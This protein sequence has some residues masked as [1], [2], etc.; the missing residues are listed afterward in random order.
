[1]DKAAPDCEDPALVAGHRY[2]GPHRSRHGVLP[3][4]VEAPIHGD[5][6]A[7]DPPGEDVHC[8]QLFPSGVPSQS[9]PQ[10]RLVERAS[11]RLAS[12]RAPARNP[13]DWITQVSL[14]AQ[15]A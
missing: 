5:L 7:I 1:M 2:D 12:H 15:S 4:Q 8:E 10:D 6:T 11:H 14:M 13:L 9:F 3:D